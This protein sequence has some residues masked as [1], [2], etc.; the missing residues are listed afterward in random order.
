[1]SFVPHT[2]RVIL[3]LLTVHIGF[4]IYINILVR[5][6]LLLLRGH[7]THTHDFVSFGP[8]TTNKNDAAVCQGTKQSIRNNHQ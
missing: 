7:Y 2:H 1:M 8:N 4:V 3:K 6:I 5:K